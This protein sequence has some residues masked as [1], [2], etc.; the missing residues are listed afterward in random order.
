MDIKLKLHSLNGNKMIVTI[1]GEKQC[2][3]SPNRTLFSNRCIHA[4][5]KFSQ[6]NLGPFWFMWIMNVMCINKYTVDFKCPFKFIHMWFF[7]MWTMSPMVNG[8]KWWWWSNI[9]YEFDICWYSY[10]ANVNWEPPVN[11]SIFSIGF[12]I[13]F[14]FGHF[15]FPPEREQK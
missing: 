4:I 3:T 5:H 2:L 7:W 9:F 12:E 14:N 11:T 1:H 13:I 6:S 15:H 8:L 10:W